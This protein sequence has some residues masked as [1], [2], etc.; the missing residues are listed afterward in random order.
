[1]APS[2]F[3]RSFHAFIY[4]QVVILIG[5]AALAQTSNKDAF[6]QQ[7]I[8]FVENLKI[9]KDD[10]TN[11]NKGNTVK[12]G[13]PS[14]THKMLPICD[15]RWGKYNSVGLLDVG[16]LTTAIYDTL[17]YGKE[18]VTNAFE[19]GYLQ[20]VV[21][22]Q[23]IKQGVDSAITW[24]R[25]DLPAAKTSVFVIRGTLTTY[26]AMQDIAIYALSSSIEL[27]SYGWSLDSVL[28][29]S[30]LSDLIDIISNDHFEIDTHHGKYS[31]EGAAREWSTVVIVI[32]IFIS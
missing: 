16:V 25:W 4:L 20:D 29:T 21:L 17:D 12:I 24:Q 6:A 9:T 15:V 22:N 1:M 19:G 2:V 23:T 26:D 18:A 27:V 32:V 10:V 5:I 8:S 13:Y 31:S 30:L 7:K 28:P 11:I 14:P 3:G